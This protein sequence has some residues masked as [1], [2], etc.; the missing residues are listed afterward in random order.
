MCECKKNDKYQV[1]FYYLPPPLH[2]C[3]HQNR[4]F[5]QLTNMESGSSWVEA[6]TS[7]LVMSTHP[8]QYVVFIT[9]HF[10]FFFGEKNL[11]FSPGLS[12]RKSHAL[13]V[14]NFECSWVSAGGGMR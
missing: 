5:G 9:F 2:H 1:W 14:C 12:K 8:I 3:H 4:R 13:Q 11:S 6:A 7:S 10:L